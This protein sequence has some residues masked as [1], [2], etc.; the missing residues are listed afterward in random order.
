M[1]RFRLP[2]LLLVRERMEGR[3][4]SWREVGLATGIAPQSVTNLASRT[5]T[6]VTNTRYIEALCRYFGCGPQDLMEFD[7]PLDQPY[8]CRVDELYPPAQRDD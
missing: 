3:R 4:I 7:P 2:E 6:V 1:I 8:T 5:Q